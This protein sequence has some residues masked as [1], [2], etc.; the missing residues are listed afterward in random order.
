MPEAYAFRNQKWE[1]EP[2]STLELAQHAGIAVVGSATLHQGQLTDGLPEF[3]AQ[4]LGMASDAENAI[5]FARSAPGLAAALVG[6]GRKEHVAANLKVA[7]HP[8][9]DVESWKSL[10]RKD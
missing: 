8:I 1:G 4:K 5:Q 10:F 7:A 3:I 6:M 2:V 9:A